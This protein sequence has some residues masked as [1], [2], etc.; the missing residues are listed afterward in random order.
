MAVQPANQVLYEAICEALGYSRNQKPMRE[1]A[2]RLP[3]WL[4]EATT[5]GCSQGD[6][7]VALSA[8]L[9]GGA[10]LLPSQRPAGWNPEYDEY[11]EEA[12]Q[13]WM[14]VAA[15]WDLTP[16]A[17][18]AWH[19]GHTRPDNRPTRRVA[20]VGWLLAHHWEE[21]LV[22][23]LVNAVEIG[24]ATLE[25]ALCGG[26]DSAFW[27]Q[28][29]DFGYTRRSSRLIGA[30]R[31]TELAINAVVPFSYALGRKDNI[32]ELCQVALATLR[33]YP[34]RG[35]NEIT[36]YMSYEVLPLSFK[37]SACRQQGLLHIYRRWCQDKNCLECPVP[38]DPDGLE[39]C[40]ALS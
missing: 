32:P 3:L 40:S 25:A 15:Q 38:N 20:A 5:A 10:G 34:H 29:L 14:S 11:L 12:E 24:P 4:L 6:R 17:H 7:E 19:F 35:D 28:R 36:R 13:T 31:A 37:S 21:G 8:I 9:L 18:Q 2:R 30:S 27:G 16:M 26:E 1:L 33:A 23:S 39:G 22:P